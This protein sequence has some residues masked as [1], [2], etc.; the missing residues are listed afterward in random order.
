MIMSVAVGSR[1]GALFAVMVPATSGGYLKR[2]VYFCLKRQKIC[3]SHDVKGGITSTWHNKHV[4]FLLIKWQTRSLFSL[5]LSVPRASSTHHHQH[6]SQSTTHLYIFIIGVRPLTARSATHSWKFRC[7]SLLSGERRLSALS[8]RPIQKS[9][10]KSSHW[11]A[12][13][14]QMINDT[15]V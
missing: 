3:T 4:F 11:N 14:D 13:C 2:W 1:R 5:C 6:S 8:L 10:A 9:H 7:P 12:R 15:L